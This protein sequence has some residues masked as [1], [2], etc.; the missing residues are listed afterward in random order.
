[1]KEKVSG[2]SIGNMQVKPHPR[3]SGVVRHFLVIESDRHAVM[4]IF[5]D[6]NT[7]IVFNYG[8]ALYDQPDLHATPVMLPECFLYGQ[9]DTFRNVSTHGRIRLL[10]AV[11]HPFGAS[12]LFRLPASELRNQ[13]L[14]CEDLFGP[15]ARSLA[16]A[17]AM[18]T[19]IEEKISV[20]ER[21][22]ITRLDT[23]HAADRLITGVV[24]LIHTHHGL[25]A[26]SRLTELSGLTERQLQR[27]F[28][29]HIGIPPKRYAGIARMQYALK[30]LRK[31][32]A[33]LSLAGVACD[34]GFFDQAHLIR[35]MKNLSGLTPGQYLNQGNLLAANLIPLAH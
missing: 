28:E 5:S 33:D 29:A 18:S 15:E 4:R 23:P 6:G 34:S 31:K 19:G 25:I 20:A 30:M 35:E 8:D 13:I 10:I 27:K 17:I 9:L 12:A 2:R 24:S 11:L 14:G 22:L 26:M 21:F 3:L 16:D 7:G 32:P 1:M